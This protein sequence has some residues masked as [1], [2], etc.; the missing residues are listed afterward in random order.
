MKYVTEVEVMQ[1]DGTAK[2]AQEISDWANGTCIDADEPWVEYEVPDWNPE[3]AY[4]LLVH[5]RDGIKKADR[6]DFVAKTASDDF[7]LIRKDT[8]VDYYQVFDYQEKRALNLEKLFETIEH[9]S[10][11]GLTSLHA[12]KEEV[13]RLERE[14]RLFL[15]QRNLAG[16]KLQEYLVDL[17]TAR[18]ERW[19]AESR[20][21]E[22]T[23]EVERL[24]SGN[25]TK[26][27][28]H[29]ICH[30]LHGKVSI[31]EFA[32]GCRKEMLKV[33]GECP[34]PEKKE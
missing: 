29:N 12:L 11:I 31:G 15:G 18:T 13:T 22:L 16:L 24:S 10:V 30:N 8:F 26:E 21:R 17:E 14:N 2:S 1:F 9:D 28:I 7:Y 19:E 27:E 6:G 33:Y 20:S 34:W 4:G 32:E 25:W 23:K 5:E 3:I